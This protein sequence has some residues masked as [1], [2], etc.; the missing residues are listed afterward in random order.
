MHQ[1]SEDNYVVQHNLWC[2]NLKHNAPSAEV[3]M[4]LLRTSKSF[5]FV[6]QARKSMMMVSNVNF[7]KIL[8]AAAQIH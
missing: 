6:Q 7:Q 4:F 5:I 8:V 2:G 1:Q 3:G